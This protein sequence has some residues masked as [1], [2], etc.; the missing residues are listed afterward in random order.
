M[1]AVIVSG[2]PNGKAEAARSRTTPSSNQRRQRARFL[3][4]DYAERLVATSPLRC[5]VGPSILLFQKPSRALAGFSTGLFDCAPPP[6][7]LRRSAHN[8][9]ARAAP[10]HKDVG[11]LSICGASAPFFLGSAGE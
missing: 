9:C 8:D 6:P 11:S 2:A 5:V 4:I 7:F 3:S 1:H 10:W